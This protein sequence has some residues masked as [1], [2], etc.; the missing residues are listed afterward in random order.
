[1]KVLTTLAEGRYFLG[2]AALIN[3][4]VHHG[5][6]IDKIVIGYRDELPKWLP[7]LK[8]TANGHQFSLSMGVPVELIEMAGSLHMVHEKPN[9]FRYLMEELEPA[10]EEFFFFDSD[11]IV[12]A[13]MSFF[14]EWVQQGVAVCGDI[15]YVFSHRHP[16]RIQWAKLAETEGQLVKNTYDQ[17]Y[18][19]GFLG[20]RRE[21]NEFITDWNNAFQLLAPHSGGMKQFR[22]KDRTEMVLSANQDSL[23]VAMMITEVPTSTIGPEAM[24]FE[25]GLQ[26]MHHPLGPKPWNRNF[27]L[28]FFKGMPPRQADIK[29]WENVNGPEFKPVK[30]HKVIWNILVCKAFRFL[31]RFYRKY[32][33]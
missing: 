8:P 33:G 15:N 23:N 22:V 6:Y 18:N 4:V 26:L 2:A 12:N 3:S 21:H 1:M 5:T 30:K 27:F 9:W 28:D 17:Y 29:Y 13:R 11:I 32:G 19:S 25:Y 10:A 20:W 16:I 14:G 24:G 31:G 7:E